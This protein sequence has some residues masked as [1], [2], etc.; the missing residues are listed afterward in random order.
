[1]DDDDVAV[2]LLRALALHAAASSW[3]GMNA[4]VNRD[5]D[6]E[7]L[8]TADKFLAWLMIGVKT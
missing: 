8:K 4:L 1:M 3:S 5:R 2:L 7:I 6:A